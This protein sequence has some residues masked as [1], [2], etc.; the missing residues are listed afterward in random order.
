MASGQ[1]E[2]FLELNHDGAIGDAM[3]VGYSKFIEA[4]HESLDKHNNF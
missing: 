2:Q 4:S 3:G 1:D